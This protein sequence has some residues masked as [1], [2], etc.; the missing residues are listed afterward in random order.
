[1]ERDGDG[2]ARCEF[3]DGKALSGK[4]AEYK[5]RGNK[6]SKLEGVPHQGEGEQQGEVPDLSEGEAKY[7]QYKIRDMYVNKP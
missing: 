1:M 7:E 5:E 4:Y 2:K 3:Y 6:R